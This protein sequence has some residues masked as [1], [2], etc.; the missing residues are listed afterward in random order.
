M[1]HLISSQRDLNGRIARA[2]ENLKKLGANNLTKGNVTSRLETLRK[3][4]SKFEAQQDQLRALAVSD[5]VLASSDY[6]KDKDLTSAATE[7]V[8]NVQEALL[9]DKLDEFSK[10]EKAAARAVARLSRDESEYDHAE[11]GRSKASL[12]RIPLPTFDGK[13]KDWPSFQG[14][15]R[16]LVILDKSLTDAERLHYLRGALT[17]DAEL[18][19]RNMPER[20][21]NFEAAWQLL[22]ERYDNQRLA[23]K[24]IMTN[25]FGLPTLTQESG[26]ELKRI[27]YTVW[28]AVK[29]LATL[30]RPFD[31]T[32]D[33]LVHLVADRMD[34][35]SRKEWETQI[36]RTRTP[37]T[38]SELQEFLE[39]RVNT[40]EAL[41]ES[42]KGPDRPP[43]QARPA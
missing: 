40:V 8:F 14:L 7:E 19:L 9:L 20:E 31:T 27:F 24:A 30:K 41:E 29:A 18:L 11:V 21:E 17:G 42:R 13:H 1:S 39:G 5:A 33:W 28:D 15:F 12:P 23:V 32:G 22:Q 3:N 6:F 43:R 4:W 34:P 37:P 16:S 35:Q 10:L 38:F 25:L 2:F 36:A 26:P